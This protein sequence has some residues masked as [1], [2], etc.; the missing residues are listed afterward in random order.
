MSFFFFKHK[1]LLFKINY[2]TKRKEISNNKTQNNFLKIK[3][4]T[5]FRKLSQKYFLKNYLFIFLGVK[6]D[7]L[8]I[9]KNKKFKEKKR[10]LYDHPQPNKVAKRR[11]PCGYPAA[12]ASNK[13]VFFFFFFFFFKKKINFKKI[14]KFF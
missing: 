14:K 1:T 12:P 2:Q 11:W 3:H 7:L 4:K 10:W 8:F 5:G 9:K 6:V 13:N